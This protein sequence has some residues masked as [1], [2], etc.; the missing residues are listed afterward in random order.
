MKVLIVGATGKFAKSGR[1]VIFA[2]LIRQHGCRSYSLD[3]GDS[4]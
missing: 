4:K 2:R 3:K 1:T